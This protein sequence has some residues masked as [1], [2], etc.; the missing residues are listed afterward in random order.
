MQC[1]DTGL[2]F[3]YLRDQVED[4]FLIERFKQ[5]WTFSSKL[6]DGQQNGIHQLN[7]D[8]IIGK[9]YSATYCNVFARFYF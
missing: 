3:L 9:Q 4:F 2:E 7:R 6:L 5:S 1:D 8:R